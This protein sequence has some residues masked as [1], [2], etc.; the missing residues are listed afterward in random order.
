[1]MTITCPNWVKPLRPGTKFCGNCGSLITSVSPSKSATTPERA[2][3]AAQPG[4][5]LCPHCGKPLR[6][7]AK[8][9]NNC[10]KQVPEGAQVSVT[11]PEVPQSAIPMVGVKPM[12]PS[13]GPIA[14]SAPTTAPERRPARKRVWTWLL[15]SLLSIVCVI[16]LAG[17]YIFRKDP[18]GWFGKTKLT[19]AA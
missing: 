5:G 1:M 15:L 17:V 18:L 8:F 9:C 13:P 4:S 16:V 7:G 11:S 3:S 2:L 19:P 6:K 14:R 10:G 12:T